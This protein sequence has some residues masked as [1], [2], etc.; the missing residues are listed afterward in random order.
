[1]RPTK[2]LID[3]QPAHVESSIEVAWIWSRRK[4]ARDVR[5]DDKLDAQ[6]AGPASPATVG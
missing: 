6:P 4:R 5:V 3:P 1:L 2:G